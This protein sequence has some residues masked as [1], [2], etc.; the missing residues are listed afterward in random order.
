MEKKMRV[1]VTG[2]KGQLGSDCISE[3]EHRGHFVIKG[4]DVDEMDITNSDA[5]NKVINEFKPDAVIHCAAWTAVDKAEQFPDDVYKV[6]AIGTKNIAEACKKVDSKMVYISTDY[7]FDGCGDKPFEV[8]APKKGLSVYGKSK[9]SG[10]DFVLSTLEKFFIVRISWAFGQNGNNFV[11]T[12]LKLA[13]AGHKELNVVCDQ[14]GSVTYTKDLA[15]LLV[16]MIETDKFGI[17]H[18]TNEGYISWADFAEE[19]FKMAHKDVHVNRVTT[20][21]YLALMPAQARRPLNSRLS[22]SSL[23]EAGFNR[24]PHYKDALK[25]YLKGE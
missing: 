15:K 10:E 21:Q 19:I 8:D 9:S 11:K 18:A 14:I 23:D 3:L 6:N 22:K 17:Y 5:V 24:L 16:D 2:A 20:E 13:D 4:V 25:R 7:V 12:M 1:L